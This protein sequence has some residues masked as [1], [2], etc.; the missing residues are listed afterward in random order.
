[1]IGKMR[2]GAEDV[3][4]HLTATNVLMKKDAY[5]SMCV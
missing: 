4:S 1:M 3:K 2:Y 5:K